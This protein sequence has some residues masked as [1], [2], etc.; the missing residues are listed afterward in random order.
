MSDASPHATIK[1]HRDLIAWQKA[2]LL[3]TDVYALTKTFPR[4]EMYGLTAQIR[5]AAA[6]VPANIA[7]GQGRRYGREFHQFL[8][9]A[10]GSLM[11]LDTHLELALRVGYLNEDQHTAVRAKLDEVGRIL[12]GLMRSISSDI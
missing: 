11:E 6:S 1:S 10:R 2:M 3:V 4:E 9:N 7:E 12:N 8:G 5:R